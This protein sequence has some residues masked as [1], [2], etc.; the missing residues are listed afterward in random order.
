M[1]LGLPNSVPSSSSLFLPSPRGS[2]DLRS[3]ASLKFADHAEHFSLLLHKQLHLPTPP[4]GLYSHPTIRMGITDFFSDLLTAATSVTEAHAE[5]PSSGASA[6][7][8]ASGTDEET[9]GEQEVNQK[10]AKS[11]DE[12]EE[13]GGSDDGGD[14]EEEG[15]DEEEEE[16]EEEEE[17]EDPK[18]KLE[19]GELTQNLVTR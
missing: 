9:E 6:D 11:G 13:S 8:P 7:S 10:E 14:G 2:T 5:A 18:P 4:I 3:G 17:P 1:L 12:G 19:E 16:E 15:G